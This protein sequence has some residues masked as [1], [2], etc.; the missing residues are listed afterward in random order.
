MRWLT[1]NGFLFFS[2]RIGVFF[3]QKRVPGG[4]DVWGQTP[5]RLILSQPYVRAHRL[6]KYGFHSTENNPSINI[7]SV[8]K[9]PRSVCV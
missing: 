4:S 9:I 7:Y 3:L 8:N 1:Y 5:H 2:Q 6:G